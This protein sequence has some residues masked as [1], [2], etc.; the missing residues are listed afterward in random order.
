MSHEKKKS[1]MFVRRYCNETH[2]KVAGRVKD[3]VQ[4]FLPDL[5]Q[6]HTLC[7]GELDNTGSCQGDSGGPLVRFNTTIKRYVQ[8]G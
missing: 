7:A 5:F 4:K 1:E 6:L 8:V 3:E 2:E